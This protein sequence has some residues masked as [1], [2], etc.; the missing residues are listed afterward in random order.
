MQRRAEY[1]QE[2]QREQA[3]ANHGD[4]PEKPRVGAGP[5]R[6]GRQLV[7][8]RG[9]RREQG[10]EDQDQ[11]VGGH[12]GR[13]RRPQDGERP[14]GRPAPPPSGARPPSRTNRRQATR[15]SARRAPSGNTRP[16]P[17]TTASSIG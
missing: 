17:S 11:E 16:T 14:G 3:A 13:G 6:R 7:V 15:R 5:Y 12:R 10:L 9:A 2:R 8:L 1:D 4:P